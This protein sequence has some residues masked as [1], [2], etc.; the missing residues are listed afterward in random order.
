MFL[1]VYDGQGDR[2]EAIFKGRIRIPSIAQ[3]TDSAQLC[4]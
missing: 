2:G 4:R 3:E 1:I